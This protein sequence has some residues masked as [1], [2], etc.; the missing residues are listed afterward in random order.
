MLVILAVIAFAL[1]FLFHGFG[2]APNNWLDWQSLMVLGLLLFA[3]SG[4]SWP[5]VIVRRRAE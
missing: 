3:L 4:A 5:A 2:F 1:S